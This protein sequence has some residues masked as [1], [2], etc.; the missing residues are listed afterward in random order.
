MHL[1]Y[2]CA[3]ATIVALDG[4]SAESGLSRVSP[5]REEQV[6]LCD[7]NDFTALRRLV[8]LEAFN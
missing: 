7:H 2:E 1:I 8:G 4:T 3:W 5:D 6:S